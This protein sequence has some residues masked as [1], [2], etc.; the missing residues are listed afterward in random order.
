MVSNRPGKAVLGMLWRPVRN[1]D[2][3]KV[4]SAREALLAVALDAVDTI[5]NPG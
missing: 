5:R 1:L 4:E 3:A 2:A